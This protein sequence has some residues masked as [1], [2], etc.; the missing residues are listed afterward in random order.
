MSEPKEV[1]KAM[2][3]VAG[4]GYQLQTAI[5][6]KSSGGG[7]DPVIPPGGDEGG[8]GSGTPPP[9]GDGEGGEGSGTPPP[10]PSE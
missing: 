4:A 6:P 2:S 1:L 3:A 8:E 10:P 5:A 7:E 9:P